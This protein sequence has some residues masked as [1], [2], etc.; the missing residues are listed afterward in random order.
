[1][2]ERHIFASTGLL[3][4]LLLTVIFATQAQASTTVGVGTCNT[5]IPYYSTISEAVASAPAGSTIKICPGTYPEQVTI[6]KNLTLEGVSSS[7]AF[8][9]VVTSPASGVVA[10]TTDLYP[11]GGPGQPIAAQIAVLTPEKNGT[12]GSPIKV[13]I[14]DLAVDGSNNGLSGCTTDLVGIYYQ[15][16]SGTIKNVA[17]RYQ[18]LDPSDFGCQDGL[19]IFV[20]SGYGTGGTA[21][22]TIEDSSVHDY[23]KNGITVDG[24]GTTATISGNY[25]VGIGATPLIAQNGI[26]VSD[27]A[28]GKVSSNT[29][30]DD[31]YVNPSDCSSNGSCYSA[32]GILLYDTGGSASNQVT[33]SGNTVSNTQGAIVAVGDSNGTADYNSVSTNKVTSTPAIAVTGY[34]YLLDGIDLCSNNNTA[35]GNTVFYS[36]GAGVHIDSSCTEATGPTGM[37]TS[38]ADTTANEACAGVLTGNNEGTSAASGTTAYNVVAIVATTDTCPAGP[39]EPAQKV[40]GRDHAVRP[41]PYARKGK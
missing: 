31:V 40:S 37:N 14:S 3:C 27:G 39:A 36:S 18:E 29:V 10:N 19:A 4:G 34:T 41:S 35:T 21:S 5:A 8:N 20:E 13:S 24:S 6:T 7:G 32:S 2:T 22:V 30:T 33:V 23:D 25:V 12:A 38:V 17:T 15:N 26:Q 9:A 28:T 11:A 1:M 16:A